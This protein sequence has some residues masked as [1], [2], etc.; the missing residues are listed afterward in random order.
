MRKDHKAWESEGVCCL[1]V[2][3]LERKVWIYPLVLVSSLCCGKVGRTNTIQ[4]PKHQTPKR[5]KGLTVNIVY[6]ANH[7]NLSCIQR[8]SVIVISHGRT[9]KRESDDY[10]CRSNIPFHNFPSPPHKPFSAS[11]KFSDW[12]IGRH[13]TDI[14]CRICRRIDHHRFE[15]TVQEAA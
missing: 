8:A 9:T 13:C 3:V 15:E 4:K 10:S 12:T 14:L 5:F 7:R 2:S 6:P 1:I 11:L